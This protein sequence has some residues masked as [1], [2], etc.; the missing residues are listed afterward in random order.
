MCHRG[1]SRNKNG[2]KKKEYFCH[3]DGFYNEYKNRKK[4]LKSQGSNK[5][6][7]S[8]PSMMKYKKENG[9][10]LVQFIKSHIGLDN[11]IGRLNLKKD[12]RAEIAGKRLYSN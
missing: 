6:N 5:I 9:V 1:M 4:Q 8:C 12:E 7:R 2:T 11:N 3:S 10:V